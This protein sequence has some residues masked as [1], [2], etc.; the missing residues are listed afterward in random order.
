MAK[1]RN[2]RAHALELQ[3]LNGLGFPLTLKAEIG[4]LD[5]EIA[6]RAKENEVAG[7]L[8]RCPA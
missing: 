5:G 3:A 1:R 2:R 4:R 8:L 7:R 6:R